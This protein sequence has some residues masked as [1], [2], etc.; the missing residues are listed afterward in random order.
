MAAPYGQGQIPQERQ[1]PEANRPYKVLIIEDEP[2]IMELVQVTLTNEHYELLPAIDGEQGLELAMSQKPDLVLLDIML[3]K[4]DGY[5]ICR[6]LKSNP[7]TARIPV[8]MLTAF[9]QKREIEEGFKVKAD[10]YI[11]KPFEPL[12]L[13]E[14]IR[15]FLT[16]DRT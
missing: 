8:L 1:M 4:M 7:A 13:R 2:D 14:R 3:P 16:P 9:G 10:D 11:V 12:A 15:R 6:R 5:E